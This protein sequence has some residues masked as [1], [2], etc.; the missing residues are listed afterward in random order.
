MTRLAF[1]YLCRY[2]KADLM[3]HL[4]FSLMILL[5]I[6]S[7][8]SDAKVSNEEAQENAQVDV[9][10]DR[11]LTMEIEGMVCEMGCGSSIR[12]ELVGLGGVSAVEFDFE[13]ERASNTAKIAFDKDKVS[14]DEIVKAIGEINKG[15]FTVGKVSSETLQESHVHQNESAHAEE[16]AQTEV[17]SVGFEIPNLLD[18]FAEIM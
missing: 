15:Q 1:A 6:S 11:M 13:E 16:K 14:V 9:V 2:S 3:K 18:F 17:Q 10:P 4:I 8:S 12:K 5:V 7:C